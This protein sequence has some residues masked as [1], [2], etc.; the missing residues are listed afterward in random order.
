MVLPII[1][2]AALPWPA[3]VAPLLSLVRHGAVTWDLKSSIEL[4]S[5]NPPCGCG[6]ETRECLSP[7]EKA[8]RAAAH[9]APWLTPA[10]PLLLAPSRAEDTQTGAIGST[11]TGSLLTRSWLS[12]QDTR[13]TYDPDALLLTPA[14]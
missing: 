4:G 6:E 1:L 13:H 8:H 11:T 5:N 2:E 10:P 14:V 3:R 7:G 9:L 12:S